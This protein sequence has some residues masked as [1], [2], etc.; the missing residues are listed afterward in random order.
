[1]LNGRY[2]FFFPTETSQRPMFDLFGTAERDKKWVVYEG[3]HSVPR[4]KL[5]EETLNWLDRYLGPVAR[6]G[7]AHDR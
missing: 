1:M 4:V 3:A 2:D 6:S 7:A 5:I